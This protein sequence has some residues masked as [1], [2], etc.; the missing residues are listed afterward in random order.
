MTRDKT[1][2]YAELDCF[3]DVVEGYCFLPTLQVEFD[4]LMRDGF[5][6]E[7]CF[8]ALRVDDETGHPVCGLGS[9]IG[10]DERVEILRALET[11]AESYWHTGDLED[12]CSAGPL[13]DAA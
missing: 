8:Q 13:T 9:E 5:A 10:G 6:E 7:V 11:L 2:L 1:V 3:E 4:A 12:C